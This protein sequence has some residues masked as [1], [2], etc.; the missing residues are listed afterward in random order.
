[1]EVVSENLYIL[2]TMRESRL[3][4]VG[5]S[6]I[7]YG[8]G[9]GNVPRFLHT[10]WGLFPV[11]VF[12]FSIV[13][14]LSSVIPLEKSF[15]EK[16]YASVSEGMN[17]TGPFDIFMHNFAISIVMM[18]PAI[19]FGFSIIVS[20]TTGIAVSAI[21]ILKNLNSLSLALL[22]IS[23]PSGILEFL[24]YGLASAQGLA[25]LFAVL[26]KRF[27]RELRGYLITLLMVGGLLL[28]AAF[29]ETTTTIR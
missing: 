6:D 22:L 13:F 5:K 9:R 26:E 28:V 24:A 20:S 21:S 12:V 19:G 14:L 11:T 1:M 16:I 25:S 27:S 23:T 15:A 10:K 7:E 2:Y 4:I 18:I 17:F 3:K 8:D 29:L